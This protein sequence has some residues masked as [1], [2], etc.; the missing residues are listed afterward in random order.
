M[1][2]LKT[3]FER[4]EGRE[5]D[6]FNRA[7]EKYKKINLEEKF[8]FIKNGELVIFIKTFSLADLLANK[9]WCKAVWG[10]LRWFPLACKTFEILLTEGQQ[11]AINYI[12]ETML[13]P[14]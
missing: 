9:S 10:E 14:N 4:I 11:E 7:S 8:V 2:T 12:T 5:W 1:N 13:C 3:I 6:W